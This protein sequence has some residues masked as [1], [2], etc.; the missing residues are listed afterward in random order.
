MKPKVPPFDEKAAFR[1]PGQLIWSPTEHGTL[2]SVLD[3][4][5]AFAL[6]RIPS[7]TYPTALTIRKP[8]QLQADGLVTFQGNGQAET[9]V[10]EADHVIIEGVTISQAENDAFVALSVTSG[11]VRLTNCSISS[12]LSGSLAVANSAILDLYGCEVFGSFHPGVYLTDSAIVRIASSKIY[13]TQT[14]GILI[15]T[16]ATLFLESSLVYEHAAVGIVV[17]DAANIHV[18][19]CEIRT[20]VYTGFEVTSSGYVHLENS[21]FQEEGTGILAKGGAG[22]LLQGCR[23][24]QCPNAGLLV[25]DGAVVKASENTFSDGGE[26]ALVLLQEK[27]Y[28]CSERDKFTGTAATAIAVLSQSEFDGRGVSID[29][30]SGTGIV[31][32]GE[33]S[34]SLIETTITRVQ[35][36]GI[37]V[38]DR[39]KVELRQVTVSDLPG[40]AL[41]LSGNA[42]GSV[43]QCKF[44]GTQTVGGEFRGVGKF[45]I[46][47]SE[48]SRHSA[49]GAIFRD[50]IAMTMNNC[51]FN[52]NG[53]EGVDILGQQCVPT[54]Q[55]CKFQGN[56]IGINVTEA[57]APVLQGC[58]VSD[59]SN[60]GVSLA[61]AG[62]KF[63]AAQVTNCG[64]VGIGVAGGG[65]PTFH[66]C[67]IKDNPKIGCQ[68]QG[69]E[70]FTRF[71]GCQF[72]VTQAAI[73]VVGVAEGKAQC[74]KCKL[75]GTSSNP[76]ASALNQGTVLLTESDVF[77]GSPGV[78]LQGRDGGV[79]Q[80]SKTTIHGKWSYG[81][82]VANRGLCQGAES[83]ITECQTGGISL[84]PQGLASFQACR[85]EKNG[86]HGI[87]IRA[88]K[89]TIAGCTISQHPAGGVIS[90][91]GSTFNEKDTKYSNNGPQDVIK[92]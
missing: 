59:S 63:E 23:I 34:V 27:A 52:G 46:S 60:Y 12:V 74:D 5:D 9:V 89:L 61:G 54:F 91:Q 80:L 1:P 37:Q 41:V 75:E 56:P 84:E 3:R 57:A 50:A 69:K 32:Y 40:P 90:E 49:A 2:Q 79:L 72:S 77:G 67:V 76:V 73:G 58:I 68:I 85:V 21:T 16:D 13:K 38:R 35:Q 36:Y 83:V 8:V 20:N 87:M 19:G 86:Q 22:L 43:Q 78:A 53:L 24:S 51:T 15:D 30:L 29:G 26:A 88:G 31:S 47:D 14:Y 45:E 70:T 71:I 81:I 48:F 62:G 65:R 44:L 39:S 64:E 82:V 28:M 10:C 66:N 25:I 17:E 55:K 92:R 7:G 11:Y 4:L 6:V 33:G 18:L 42:T